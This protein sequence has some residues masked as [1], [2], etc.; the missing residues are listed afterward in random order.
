VLK[1]ST[2]P[3]KIP[4]PVYSYIYTRDNINGLHVVTPNAESL[5]PTTSYLFIF[6]FG[7]LNDDVNS[8]YIASNDWT[9][10]F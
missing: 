4:N 2:N 9:V 8:R 5:G 1:C 6:S 3:N 10:G 7:L